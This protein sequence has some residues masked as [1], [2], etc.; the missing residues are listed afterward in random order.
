MSSTKSPSL[1]QPE[2]WI[3]RTSATLSGRS[4]LLVKVDRSYAR[5]YVRAQDKAAQ[6][7]LLQALDNY[8][9]SSGKV[10]HKVSRNTDSNGLMEYIH[11]LVKEALHGKAGSLEA[12]DI[13][14]ARY[15]VLYLLG[16]TWV[17]TDGW[18]LGL[19]AVGQ[20]GG[21]VAAGMNSQLSSTAIP[22][23]LL[24]AQQVTKLG[25]VAVD[26][27]SKLVAKPAGQRHDSRTFVNAAAP[28]HNALVG[29]VLAQAYDKLKTMVANA[30]DAVVKKVQRVLITDSLTPWRVSGALLRE[31]VVKVVEFIV[32][33]AVPFLK[34]GMELGHN[35]VKAIELI[36]QNG[37]A[38]NLRR[39]R[40]DINPGHPSAI[41]NAIQMNM[42]SNLGKSVMSAGLSVGKLFLEGITAGAAVLATALS[43]ALQ[44]LVT[45]LMREYEKSN[46]QDFL[47]EARAVLKAERKLGTIDPSTKRI[48]PNLVASR[49]GL[50]ND[51]KAFTAFFNRGCKAS[52]T[53]PMLTLNSGIC[54]NA[55]TYTKMYESDANN[56]KVIGQTT[57]DN[58]TAF[59][60]Y[61]KATGARYLRNKGFS[62]SST[63]PDVNGYLMHAVR[64]HQ[65]TE[66]SAAKA[67]AFL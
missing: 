40:F 46:L 63:L 41:A 13:P 42:L 9:L 49:G 52:V 20:V 21:V 2:E 60:S 54:G 59:F 66:S 67:L 17:E 15:G 30:V 31:A 4:A 39:K 7:D 29:S 34:S 12:H 16:N 32:G 48:Q 37:V 62:F 14:H 5:W 1:V 3:A 27:A 43:S 47:S 36:Y 28:A 58:S 6:A 56:A 45:W 53:V 26:S 10:W 44:W 61:L 33:H 57:F 23:T 65:Q 24:N 38:A 51:P 22:G 8:L 25:L 64:D 19:Q 35:L 11:G 55:M 50:I 18:K